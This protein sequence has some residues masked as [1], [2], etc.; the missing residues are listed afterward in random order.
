MNDDPR[1][2]YYKRKEAKQYVGGAGVVRLLLGSTIFL[3]TIANKDSMETMHL[4]GWSL[5]GIILI[6]FGLKAYINAIKTGF[7]Q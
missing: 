3:L 1:D 5:A 6:T 2:D 7:K 4:Y